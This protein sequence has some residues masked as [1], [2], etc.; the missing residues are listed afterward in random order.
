MQ[1]YTGIQCPVCGKP[2]EKDDDIVVCPD[3]GAPYHRECYQK[4]GKCIFDELHLQGKTWFPPRTAESEKKEEPVNNA[5][6][7]S[8]EDKRPVCPVCGAPYDEN[9]QFCNFC[10]APLPHRQASGQTPPAPQWTPYGGKVPPFAFDPMGG[11][12]P[13]EALDENV[14]FGDASLLVQQNTGY[15][16]PVF[17]YIKHT[18]RNKFNFSAFFFTG[19]WLLYRKQ[20]KSGALITGL[21]LT[22]YALYMVLSLLVTAPVMIDLMEQVGVDIS[23]TLSPTNEQIM[24]MAELM[25]QDNVLFFKMFLPFL[26]LGLMLAVMIFTGV[27]GNKMYLHH[28]IRTVRQTR[29]AYSGESAQ[30]ALEIAGGVSTAAVICVI[31]CCFLLMN[32]FPLLL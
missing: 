16:M 11:V 3:C 28:C 5:E 30:S 9:A 18:G 7:P 4:E 14:T 10:G 22:I 8:R 1:D 26:C 31:A 15:Y 6:A 2:F 19:A 20:Y 13:A 32:L 29:I 17:R 21:M 23:K 12:S 24:A 27:R 25:S